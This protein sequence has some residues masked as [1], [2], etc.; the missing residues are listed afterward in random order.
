M[1]ELGILG[2]L[3]VLSVS[4]IV[5]LCGKDFDGRGLICGILVGFFIIGPAVIF[6][7]GNNSRGVH[8]GES[9]FEI[10]HQDSLSK[11]SVVILNRNSYGKFSD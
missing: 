7:S 10:V 8:H 5:I 2:G 11:D 6:W 1:F 4:A 9:T 3:L